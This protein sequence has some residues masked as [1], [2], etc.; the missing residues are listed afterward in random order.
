MGDLTG[1][2]MSSVFWEMKETSSKMKGNLASV[3][4]PGKTVDPCGTGP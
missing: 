3:L 4:L 1:Q 2:R